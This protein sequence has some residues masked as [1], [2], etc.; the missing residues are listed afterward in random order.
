MSRRIGRRP[1]KEEKAHPAYKR[2]QRKFRI[3]IVVGI[4]I[5][6]LAFLPIP[7]YVLFVALVLLC[8]Q[9]L[10]WMQPERKELEAWR[11]EH[12]SQSASHPQSVNSEESEKA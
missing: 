3:F 5:V 12:E 11:R 7:F 2:A 9:Y 6:L 1:S 4:A 8:I 10:R